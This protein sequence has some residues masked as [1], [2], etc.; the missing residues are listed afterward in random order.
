[1]QDIGGTADWDSKQDA[2]TRFT[3]ILPLRGRGALHELGGRLR[4]K[5][6]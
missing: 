4:R 3:A 5:R 6:R 1:M 2:G